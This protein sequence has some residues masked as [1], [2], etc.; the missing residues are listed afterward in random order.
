MG[1]AEEM[2]VLTTQDWPY[3]VSEFKCH[4]CGNCC[5][6]DGYVELTETDI[7][8]IAEY[9]GLRRR[10]FLDT[11]CKWDEETRRWHLI[12][13]SDPEQSCVFLST[14]NKCRVNEVKPS[15]CRGFPMRWR[16]ENILD[17]CAGWRAAAGLP[18][19]EKKTMT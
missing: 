2:A 19:A 13:Q 7:E 6:G 9:L 3:E 1:L 12:D 17:F 8:A 15:Q 11:Y 14:D 16:P 4:L 5:R 18:P 10:E